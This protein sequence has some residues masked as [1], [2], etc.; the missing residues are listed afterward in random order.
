[1]LL[2]DL[3]EDR[4]LESGQWLGL[5]VAPQNLEDTLARVPTDEGAVAPAGDVDAP[6]DGREAADDLLALLDDIVDVYLTTETA[7]PRMD[8]T[9]PGAVL[10]RSM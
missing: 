3:R 6:V 8:A 7:F 9:S 5:R 4:E 1:M 10:L 2:D